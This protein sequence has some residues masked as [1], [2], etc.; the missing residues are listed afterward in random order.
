MIWPGLAIMIQ[1]M[2]PVQFALILG[3]LTALAAAA[4]VIALRK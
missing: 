4:C 3:A 1:S 2:N